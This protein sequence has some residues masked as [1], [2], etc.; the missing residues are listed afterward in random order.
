MNFDLIIESVLNE[1]SVPELDLQRY[2]LYID[3]NDHH[4]KCIMH[5]Q[6]LDSDNVAKDNIETVNFVIQ[7]FHK[8]IYQDLS[9]KEVERVKKLFKLDFMEKKATEYALGGLEEFTKHYKENLDNVK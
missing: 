4:L 1:E 8:D 3:L 7:N 5:H 6:H 2:K 9:H